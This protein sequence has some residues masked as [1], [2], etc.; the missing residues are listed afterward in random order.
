MKKSDRKKQLKIKFLFYIIEKP[1]FYSRIFNLNIFSFFDF[2]FHE[3]YYFIIRDL[4][5][6]EFFN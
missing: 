2:F 4:F 6:V 3:F 5:P 1:A